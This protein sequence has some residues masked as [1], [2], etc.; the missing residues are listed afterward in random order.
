MFRSTTYAIDLH[1]LYADLLSLLQEFLSS[2]GIVH[3]DLACRNILVG[4]GKDLK[5]SDF[6]MARATVDEVLEPILR[7]LCIEHEIRQHSL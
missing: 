7:F 5:I 4:E 3:R 2:L 6:G 1:L